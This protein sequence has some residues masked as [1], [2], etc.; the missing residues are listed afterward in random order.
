MIRERLS[1]EQ[2]NTIVRSVEIFNSDCAQALTQPEYSTVAALQALSNASHALAAI[3]GAQTDRMTRDDG[4]QLLSIG[5][6]V[7]R[8]GFLSLALTF[9]LEAGALN[10]APQGPAGFTALL[11]L[12]DSTITFRAQHQQSRE[13]AALVDLLIKDKENPRSLN[14]VAG[15]LRARLSKLAGTPMG[16]PDDL[17]RML[18]TLDHLSLDVLCQPDAQHH[19]TSLQE[20]LAQC[21]RS[22]WQISDGISA[23]YFSHT[24][25]TDYTVGA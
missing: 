12:F 7:E 1:P 14:W 8:L 21:L 24:H 15:H 23:K 25:V 6:H 5:R 20:V 16:T 13:L 3:T 18:P 10:K 11:N 19:L 22:S 4:W 2:W 17:A 9:A